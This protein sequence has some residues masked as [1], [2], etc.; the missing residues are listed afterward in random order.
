MYKNNYVGQNR[1]ILE[2]KGPGPNCQLLI[3]VNYCLLQVSFDL[4]TLFF[5]QEKFE[6]ARKM[7]ESCEHAKVINITGCTSIH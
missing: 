1:V 6:Q 7:F 2:E 5:Y 4:G 3:C